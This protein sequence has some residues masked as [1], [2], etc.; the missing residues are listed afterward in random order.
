MPI[1]INPQRVFMIKPNYQGMIF[2]QTSQCINTECNQHALS[3]LSCRQ[4]LLTD[5]VGQS[6]NMIPDDVIQETIIIMHEHSPEFSQYIGQLTPAQLHLLTVSNGQSAI[7]VIPK[8]KM[9]INTHYI[10][11]H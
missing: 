2:D 9:S 8:D 5:L 3:S 11:E 7:P 1:M 4:S 6:G 10:D